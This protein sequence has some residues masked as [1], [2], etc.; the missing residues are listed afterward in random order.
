M[1]FIIL[2]LISFSVH[3]S[4]AQKYAVAFNGHIDTTLIHSME[5]N[6][7]Q[8]QHVFKVKINYKPEKEKGELIIQLVEEENRSEGE[9]NSEF[10]I[11]EIKAYLISR[12][13]T[14]VSFI[15]LEK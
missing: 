10:S 8:F 6:C 1:K 12:E 11:A 5:L 15:T 4:W 9:Q 3:F 2:I 7:E 13:L 14:P